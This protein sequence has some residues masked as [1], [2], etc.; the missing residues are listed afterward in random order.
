MGDDHD[1]QEWT[2]FIF[3]FGLVVGSLGRPEVGAFF[4]QRGIGPEDLANFR[5]LG[6]TL[7]NAFYAAPT[8]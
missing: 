4:E 5:E 2:D 1:T 7:A 6:K 8:V 3:A